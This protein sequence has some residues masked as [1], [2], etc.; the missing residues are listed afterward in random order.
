MRL[1]AVLALCLFSVVLPTSAQQ[2]AHVV[3]MDGKAVVTLDLKSGKVESSAALGFTPDRA[4]LSPDG[5]TMLALFQGPGTYGFW[6]AE[7]RPKGPSHAAVL[8]D[9]KVVGQTELG[10]GLAQAAF[11]RDGKSAYVLTTGYESNKVQERKPS[12]LLRIDLSNGQIA[13]RISFDA[14][15]EA[16]ATDGTGRIGIVYAP[17]YPKKK[18]APLPARITFIDLGSFKA[19]KTIELAGEVMRPVSVGDLLY[20]A[21][22][23][24]R[25]KPG[26][27][28]IVDAAKQALA[29][30]IPVGPDP[31]IAG[32]DAQGRIVVLSDADKKSGRVTLLKGTAVAA[33]YAGPAQPR[34][35]ATSA[36]GSKLYVTG[37]NDF[38]LI[39]LE[40]GKAS[41]PAELA[42]WPFALVPTT[43]G[44]RVFAVS[45]D[46]DSC[47]R[48]STLD[49][50][51]MKR[52]TSFLGGSK[53]ERIGQGLAAAALTAASYQ[54]GKSAAQSSGSNTFYY[55]IYA[56]TTRGP[57]RGP[58]AF[59]PGEKKVY[60]VD[61]QTNDVT[62]VDV[63][64]GERIKNIDAGSGLKEVIALP[65]AGV[66]AAI[67]D[68]AV[69][70]IDV[71]TDE[72]RDTVKLSGNVV[73]AVLTPDAKR[74]VVFGKERVVVLDAT[75][76]K[77]V[78]R[79]E[80]LKQPLQVLFS[81]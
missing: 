75:T 2:R 52:L 72:V 44:T 27:V 10:W 61:T 6:V 35:V 81:E 79:T 31:A 29:A 19:G 5:K 41:G 17:A 12:E 47:C 39:D 69:T 77:E 64:T 32:S 25:K 34:R 73:D 28:Y 42:R 58:L 63:A 23:N 40:D 16:F 71:N 57:A 7:F 43:D 8:R 46:G 9:G 67:A 13:E 26:R 70:M 53:G 55:S 22:G 62:S 15:S 33:E 21:E 24:D 18:P 37:V 36:D 80:S 59:G 60:L 48:L 74:V 78:A 56:P 68:S 49:V 54:A 51:A 3:D 76:G 14:A 65:E 66:I 20:F 50:G 38:V 30:T 45:Y 11:S 1:Y 4:L